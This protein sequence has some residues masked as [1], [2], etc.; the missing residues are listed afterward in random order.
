MP[1][2]YEEYASKVTPRSKLDQQLDSM[3][4]GVDVHLTKIA[5]DLLNLDQL[6]AALRLKQIYLQDIQDR[7]YG[8]RQKYVLPYYPKTKQQNCMLKSIL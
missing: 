5:E 1:L 7:F 6:T 8:S 2:K 3:N 4:D